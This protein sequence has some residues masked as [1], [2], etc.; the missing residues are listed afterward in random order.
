MSE[1]KTL[2]E[3]IEELRAIPA[4][5]KYLDDPV[6]ELRRIREDPTYVPDT[7]IAKERR[8][9]DEASENPVGYYVSSAEPISPSVEEMVRFETESSKLTA[10]P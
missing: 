10:L 1:R 4:T 6:G 7:T 5:W 3:S 8:R 2:R 9:L